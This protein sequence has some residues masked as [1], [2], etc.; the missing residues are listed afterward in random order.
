[1]RWLASHRGDRC[2]CG[3]GLG[4]CK[5]QFKSLQGRR[6]TASFLGS[7][8][9]GALQPPPSALPCH[10]PVA[11]SPPSACRSMCAPGS[12]SLRRCLPHG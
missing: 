10:P 12:C 5:V 3:L 1:M 11:P 4:R 8:A 9:A 7:C 6:S 2:S